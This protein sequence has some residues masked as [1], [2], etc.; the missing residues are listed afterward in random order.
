[1]EIILNRINIST[2]MKFN[3]RGHENIRAT[4]ATTVEFTKDS[5]L[6][7]KG[8]C[9]IGVRADFDLEQLKKLKGRVVLHIKCQG[10]EQAVSCTINPLFSDE[11]EL[12]IRK[13]SFTDS[14]TFA[15]Q[16]DKAAI[17]LDRA[18]VALLKNPDSKIQVVVE[19]KKGN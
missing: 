10:R 19:C 17:D 14:R 18:F 16:A 6:T 5:S 9:I 8:D 3:S 7:E 15:T 4:H 11:H 12:V 13:S 2:L 1:L